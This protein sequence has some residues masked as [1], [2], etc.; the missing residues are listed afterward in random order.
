MNLCTG[1][2]GAD[3]T[4][5]F[6]DPLGGV[7]KKPSLLMNYVLTCVLHYISMLGMLVFALAFGFSFRSL[8]NL[9]QVLFNSRNYV[10]NGGIIYS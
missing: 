10:K 9:S 4:G 3:L 8:K 1:L 6:R 7:E 2:F 5:I